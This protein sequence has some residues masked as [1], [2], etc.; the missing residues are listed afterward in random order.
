ML[1]KSHGLDCYDMFQSF[2]EKHFSLMKI[3]F[4]SDLIGYL[5]ILV[6]FPLYFQLHH[7]NKLLNIFQKL[8]IVIMIHIHKYE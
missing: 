2:L 6:F 7:Y 1:I 8:V 4:R 3:Y 5:E